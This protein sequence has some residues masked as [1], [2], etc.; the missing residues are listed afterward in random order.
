MSV[1]HH[2]K[3]LTRNRLSWQ[4]L[5][6]AT[7]ENITLMGAAEQT[8]L[9]W[10][11]PVKT[12]DEIPVA[13]LA[14]LHASLPDLAACL[15]AILTPTFRGFLRRENEKLVFAVDERLY[16]L[17]Q[18]PSGL[19]DTVFPLAEINYV[20]VGAILL[21]A[22]LHISGLV[23]GELKSQT[24]KYNTVTQYLFDPLVSGIRCTLSGAERSRREGEEERNRSEGD[25]LASADLRAERA[26]FEPL[27]VEHFKFMSYA[28]SCLQPG[29]RVLAYAMQPEM[30]T[31]R[32]TV[33]GRAVSM[34]I[35]DTAHLCIMTDSELIVIR[36]D[37]NS[38][39]GCDDTRY[40]G[41]WDYIPLSRVREAALEE[42]QDDLALVVRMPGGD[43]FEVMFS[44]PN[45][46]G[47]ESLWEQ[48][49]GAI[50]F[51]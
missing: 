43:T 18:A 35:I 49:E 9:S 4:R 21:K 41:I 32:L 40:G 3:Q 26:K 44:A 36:D 8:R 7:V 34:R 14:Y 51:K 11:K 37:P 42:R 28:R 15:P 33:L 19:M 23:D 50:R 25:S 2:N 5:L 17:E 38:L 24:L 46:L 12:V 22:W 13:Y 47:V 1:T 10:A 39:T 30:R 16:I 27:Q 45:R 20:E 31:P 6:H 48:M 29:Q